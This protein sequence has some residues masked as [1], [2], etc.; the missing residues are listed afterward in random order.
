MRRNREKVSSLKP[1]GS[2]LK[3]QGSNSS[4]KAWIFEWKKWPSKRN[5]WRGVTTSLRTGGQ[6]HPT[7][8]H[9]QRLTQPPFQHRHIHKKLLK[10]SFSHFLTRAQDRTDRPT[11]QWSNGPT[12]QHTDKG[13][14]RVACPQLKRKGNLF[15]I[16][17][18]EIP[19]S[20][21]K[22]NLR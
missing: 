12:D 2:S 1:Q 15:S 21:G 16:G 7:P 22:G 20:A 9:T 3:P 18:Q 14:Y 8:I 19:Q 10:R 6:G 4:I 5:K 17:Y 11:D 13:S